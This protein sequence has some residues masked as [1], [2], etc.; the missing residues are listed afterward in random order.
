MNGYEKDEKKGRDRFETLFSKRLKMEFSDIHERYDLMA[1]GYTNNNTYV[2][3][4]KNYSNPDYPRA[5]D[6]YICNGKDGGYMIDNAKLK[7]LTTIAEK[8][9]RIPILFVFFSDCLMM[10]D[11]NKTMWNDTTNTDNRQH[12]GWIR[13]NKDGQNYGNKELS[14]MSYLYK[15]EAIWIKKI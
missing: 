8:E 15:D 1:T 13:V 5:Y 10:W 3:E 12:T 4:I 11:I 9:N 2:I 7:E 6:K 14:Y